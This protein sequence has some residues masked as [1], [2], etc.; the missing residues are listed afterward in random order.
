MDNIKPVASSDLAKIFSK[1]SPFVKEVRKRIFFTLSV[2]ALATVLGFAFYENIIRF[3][4]RALSLE[5]INIVFTSPFQFINL[6][7]SCGVVTGIIAVLPVFIIQILYFLKPALKRKEFKTVTRLL[8]FSIILFFL[9]SS[10]K[11]QIEIFLA[12]SVSLGIG[13]IL[14]I[15]GL[16]STVFLTSAL[17]GVGFQFPIFLLLFMR[18]GIIEPNQLNKY[19]RWIYLGSFVFAL[20][21]PPDSILADVILSLPLIILFEFT[22]ILNRTL[23]KKSHNTSPAS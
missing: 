12:R 10:V 9:E 1:Y 8:P 20:L 3:L 6:A 15:S 14:D 17:M 22:L 23:E 16:L 11:W 13:N 21:L 5:G 4:I 19:R 2:F 7:I 18:I